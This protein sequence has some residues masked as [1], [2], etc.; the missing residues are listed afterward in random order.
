MKLASVEVDPD[1]LAGPPVTEDLTQ[2]T[3]DTAEN[4]NVNQDILAQLLPELFDTGVT[5]QMC[6]IPE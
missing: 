5:E 4:S 1:I 2:D 3:P 6:K